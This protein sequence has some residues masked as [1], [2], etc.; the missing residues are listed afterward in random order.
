MRTPNLMGFL[1]ISVSVVLLVFVS[2]GSAAAAATTTTTT[3]T[4]I[5]TT[6][7]T[8]EFLNSFEDITSGSSLALQWEEFK[9]GNVGPL[10]LNAQ[11]IDRGED[12]GKVNAY[13]VNI[14]TGVTG[15]S[16]TWTGV[17]YPLRWIKNG[18][19]QLELKPSTWTEGEVAP[20]LAKS[21]FFTIGEPVVAPASPSASSSPPKLADAPSGD[22]SSGGGVSKPLAIGLGVAIGVPSVAALIVGSWYFR[23]RQ[24]RRAVEKRRLK[25]SEFVI[26]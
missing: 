4:T 18:L 14:T 20:V 24:Q 19:Y 15:S 26:Y 11:V 3:T 10:Y 2:T 23:R 8:A 16:F 1:L 25:R 17:P 21:P 9:G 22:Q 6:T 7:T 5:T 13:R 12:G